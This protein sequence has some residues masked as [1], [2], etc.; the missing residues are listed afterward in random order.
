MGGKSNME[1]SATLQ[2][3]LAARDLAWEHLRD[4]RRLGY[5]GQR[6]GKYIFTT[7]EYKKVIVNLGT[8][9]ITVD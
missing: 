9:E 3:I 8:K 1:Y 2:N 5:R 6:Y 4:R 7:P